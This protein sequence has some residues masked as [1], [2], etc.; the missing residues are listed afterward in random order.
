MKQL[1]KTIMAYRKQNNMTIRDFANH[2]GVSTSLISQIER[3]L[4]NPSLNVLELLAQ[5][6]GVPLFTLF[7]NDIDT[8]SLISRKDERQKIYREDNVHI[9]YD[10]L[11]PDFMKTNIRVLLMEI[12][13]H[14]KTTESYYEHDDKEELAIVMRGEINVQLSDEVYPLNTGD[15]V[16]IPKNTRHR[17]INTSNSIVEVLFILTPT[18]Y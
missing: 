4:G 16:R 8:N 9:V 17:F 13:P 5:A 3:G 18:F 15:V 2:S 14:S 12:K 6:L 7:I 10:L 11:T 1:G